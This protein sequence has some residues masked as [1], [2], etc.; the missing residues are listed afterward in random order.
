M[1]DFPVDYV[2][3]EIVTRVNQK[4]NI[5]LSDEECISIKDKIASWSN[6]YTRDNQISESEFITGW[7]LDGLAELS[8]LSLKHD[9]RKALWHINPREKL[10]HDLK[11]FFQKNKFGD[12]L[13]ES[14]KNEIHGLILS[15][16]YLPEDVEIT[17]LPSNGVSALDN[18][19]NMTACIGPNQQKFIVRFNEEHQSFDQILKNPHYS[20]E[21][22]NSNKIMQIFSDFDYTINALRNTAL[23]FDLYEKFKKSLDSSESINLGPSLTEEGFLVISSYST[24]NAFSLHYTKINS[25]GSHDWEK[26]TASR[27]GDKSIETKEFKLENNGRYY[28]RGYPLVDLH[29]TSSVTL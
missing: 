5:P 24:N 29:V 11:R 20:N 22:L 26:V 15:D 18:S 9:I 25:D 13:Q 3:E 4:R 23:A 27:Y 17:I 16:L 12:S 10:S 7:E 28:F 8:D 6:R 21:T 2:V 19:G 1:R 14:R